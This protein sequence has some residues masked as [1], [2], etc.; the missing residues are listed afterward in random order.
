MMNSYSIYIWIMLGIILLIAELATPGGFVL[1]C[2]GISCFV[3]GLFSYF[4]FGSTMQILIFSIASLTL[5]FCI[6]P[7]FKKY[8]IQA[9]DKVKTNIDALEGKIGI[10]S[11]RIDPPSGK[12]R[13]MVGGE[14]WKGI[15]LADKIIDV[16][17]RI[18]VIKVDGS[19]L[20]IQQYPI[21][22]GE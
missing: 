7:L 2:L 5:F 14:D 18:I 15:S 12:G 22:K 20:V 11:E 13:V 6:R 10:V 3:A 4:G 21:H 19:K 1:A 9:S 8:L 16:G 17:Q